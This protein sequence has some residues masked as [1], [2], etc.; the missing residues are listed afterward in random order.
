M[1][2]FHFWWEKMYYS[3]LYMYHTLLGMYTVI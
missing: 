1:G 3:Y 2:D